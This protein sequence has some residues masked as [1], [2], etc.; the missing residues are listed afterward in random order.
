MAL[1]VDDALIFHGDPCEARP[2]TLATQGAA[3][4]DTTT[5]GAEHLDGD[6]VV[7]GLVIAHHHLYSALARGMPGPAEGPTRFLEV[8]EKIWWRLDRALDHELSELSAKVGTVEALR[9]GATTIVDHHASPATIG[10]SLDAVAGGIL[11]AGARGV[12]CYEATDR[13]GDDGFAA[14]LAENERMILRCAREAELG[15]RIRA[16]VGGH[17]PFTLSDEHLSALAELAAAHGTWVHL[18][19][20]EAADDQRD[21]RERGHADVT[22]RLEAAGILDGRSVL[23]HGVHLGRGEVARLGDGSWLTHQPRSNMNNHVGYFEAGR[24]H[25]RIALGTD[26]IN[27]DLFDEAHAAFFRLREHDREAD[28]AEV[29]RWIAG[30]WRLANEAFGLSPARGFGR[31]DPGCPA[32]FVVL[33][34]DGSTPVHAGSLPWHLAFGI[35]ARH[36]RHVVVGGEVVVRD[37]RSTRLDRLELR[38]QSFAGAERLWARMAALE[39]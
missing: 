14:G 34:Y 24:T 10:G 27:S 26:G 28:A 6:L 3:I 8:L 23:A 21:A 36:V 17:A 4:V 22:A 30:G 15:A 5:D 29:W 38:A 35:S 18:H 19:V 2:G 16:M 37:G 32:D 11:A 33:D 9:C 1:I 20:A 13:H 31:L 39:S 7:P 12:V 25:G